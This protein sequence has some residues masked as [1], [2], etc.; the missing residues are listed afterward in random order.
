MLKQFLI[1]KKEDQKD[2]VNTF[3]ELWKYQNDNKIIS[4]Y[5]VEYFWNI[6]ND[7]DKSL[8]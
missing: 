5:T 2:I 3:N 8:I 1:L 6:I 4:E 7:F